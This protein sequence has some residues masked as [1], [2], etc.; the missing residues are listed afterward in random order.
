MTVSKVIRSPGRR[1][2]RYSCSQSVATTE[3]HPAPSSSANISS[4]AAER[5]VPSVCPESPPIVHAW[6]IVGGATASGPR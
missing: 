1:G 3:V 2:R 5:P 4:Y 6:S